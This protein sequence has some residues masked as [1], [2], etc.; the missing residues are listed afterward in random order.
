MRAPCYSSLDD[1]LDVIAP[2]GIELKN[3][4]SNHAPMVAEALCALGRPDAVPPWIERYCARMSPRPPQGDR[5]VPGEWRTALGRRE[6]FADW[7][8]LL[9]DELDAA[10]WEAVLDR[11][12]DRLSPGFCAA[13]THGPIRVGHAVRALADSDRPARRRELA[14]ALAGWAATYSELPASAAAGNGTMRPRRAIA[15]VPVVPAEKRRAGNIVAALSVL[16]DFPQ[17]APIIG[18]ID[19]SGA[20]DTLVAGLTDTFARVFLANVHDIRTAIAF[21]H[22]VT[23]LAALGNLARHLE[24]TTMRKAACYAWQAACG[25]YACYGAVPATAEHTAPCDDNHD[26]LAERAIANGDEHVVK[27]TEACLGRNAIS[28]SPAYPA[29]IA[30]LF[31]VIVRH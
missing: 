22:G 25:L 29:A 19:T 21:I 1:A 12:V 7:A 20:I 5:I 31:G 2:Y 17:F 24:A 23:S 4:N 6:R 15:E 16:C 13:A 8:R 30:H 3:G 9:A 11:W 26:V 28:A 18:L 10:P 27:F 14:D